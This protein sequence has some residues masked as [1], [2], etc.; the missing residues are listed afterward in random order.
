MNPEFA[1]VRTHKLTIA[2]YT[3]TRAHK[4]FIGHPAT[5][6]TLVQT[7]TYITYANE[8]QR[9]HGMWQMPSSPA[10][11]LFPDRTRARLFTRGSSMAADEKLQ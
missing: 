6:Q 10:H 2:H 7:H 4:D 8:L 5:N 1:S 3:D 11:I 9:L